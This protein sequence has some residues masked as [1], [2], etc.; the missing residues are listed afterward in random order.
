MARAL[1]FSQSDDL[2]LSPKKNSLHEGGASLGRRDDYLHD[3][4]VARLQLW[5]ELGRLLTRVGTSGRGSVW[6]LGAAANPDCRAG[7]GDSPGERNG[8]LRRSPKLFTFPGDRSANLRGS[9]E[10]LPRTRGVLWDQNGRAGTRVL[11][12][13]QR[14]RLVAADWHEVDG[15]EDG[16]G[17]DLANGWSARDSP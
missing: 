3:V 15:N 13:P 14:E 1:S 16:S 5:P 6:A 2:R 11:A 7:S 17:V 9:D 4:A 12:L 10:D 8:N